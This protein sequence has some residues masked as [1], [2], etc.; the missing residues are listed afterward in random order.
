MRGD[1]SAYFTIQVRSI[2]IRFVWW[3]STPYSAA[4]AILHP[5]VTTPRFRFW[6]KSWWEWRTGRPWRGRWW[7]SRLVRLDCGGL[8]RGCFGCLIG[9]GS[10]RYSAASSTHTTTSPAFPQSHLQLC[11]PLF[12]FYYSNFPFQ[13]HPYFEFPHLHFWFWCRCWRWV[14]RF[15][16]SNCAHRLFMVEIIRLGSDQS[17][18]IVIDRYLFRRPFSDNHNSILWFNHFH[19]LLVFLNFRRRCWSFCW[20]HFSRLP[21]DSHFVL[22]FERLRR[23]EFILL[24]NSKFTPGPPS[25]SFIP[26]FVNSILFSEMV[27]SLQSHYFQLLLDLLQVHPIES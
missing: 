5:A 10:S 16:K 1:R 22:K 11:L 27:Q 15:S 17:I 4:S 2:V 7:R 20:Y 12:S 8:S 25:N 9:V 21:I 14:P 3:V 6:G 23:I 26:Q 13:S 19:F 18:L 24:L